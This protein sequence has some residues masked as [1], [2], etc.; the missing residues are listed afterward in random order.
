MA[1]QSSPSSLATD[2]HAKR[3]ASVALTPVTNVL[4]FLNSVPPHL[5]AILVNLSPYISRIR[6]FAQVSSWKSSSW[7]E[8]WLALA[9]WWALCLSLDVVLRY[10]VP[11]IMLSILYSHRKE[12]H[13]K[14]S[15]PPVSPPLVTEQA[16]QATINDLDT[17]KSLLPRFSPTPHYPFYTLLRTT[18]ILYIP[19]LFL[20]RHIS[21]RT[22]IAI[23]GSIF[24]TWRAP[25]ATVLRSTIWSSAWF[26]WSTYY[27]WSKIT[28]IPLAPSAFSQHPTSV[29][30]S[31]TNSL[32]FLFTVYEN[33]RWWVGLDWIAALL[34]GERPSWCSTNQQAVS[35]PNAFTLPDETVIYLP[36][37]TGKGRVKRTARWRWEEPEWRVMVRKE[38]NNG[39]VS[40]VEKPLPSVKEDGTAANGTGSS[41]SANV[42][43]NASKLMKSASKINDSGSTTS[44]LSNASD[45]TT[46]SESHSH[47]D[48]DRDE[49]E[50]CTDVDG[51]VYGD[52][53]WEGQGPKGGM[54]KY[55]RYRR[56]TR[57]A[58]VEE[59]VEEVGEGD[60]GIQRHRVFT[61]PET[62]P[63]LSFY[64]HEEDKVPLP[65]TK[66]MERGNSPLRQRL[67]A[68]TAK[69]G[70]T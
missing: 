62:S 2:Q 21:L 53:K 32:R 31:P 57:V 65:Q 36:N 51:W 30:P 43:S 45:G 19:Y 8:S 13:Y 38:G 33:Q 18:T 69:S 3:S 52:N 35:P 9:L 28:G 16:I 4:D 11:I 47:D 58:V 44:L 34:P 17:I 60:L 56:W 61:A 48:G 10:L 15:Q 63:P 67:K 40:R 24:L 20:T 29:A 46:E 50:P 55:T 26:R 22:I 68:L 59:T 54:G 14:Q 12:S 37:P 25:W 39:Q 27:V 7:Y 49:Q 6:F 64:H 41:L 42:A 66:P 5:A 1:P 70:T 23:L